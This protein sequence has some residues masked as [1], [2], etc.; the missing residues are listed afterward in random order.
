MEIF[1]AILLPFMLVGGSM[2]IGVAVDKSTD[3]ER[4]LAVIGT[5]IV[6]ASALLFM[7]GQNNYS[8]QEVRSTNFKI[9]TEVRL[10]I[11]NGKEIS[12][13]TVYIFTPRKK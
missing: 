12:R 7:I 3:K 13:D 1:L 9:K 11:T 4:W 2:L 5:V 6:W 8:T 10:K